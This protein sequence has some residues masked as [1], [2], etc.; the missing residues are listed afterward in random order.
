MIE[1]D[2]TQNNREFDFFEGAD[3]GAGEQ[4]MAIRPYEGAIEDPDVHNN[5]NH[6]AP[7]VE[8]ELEYVYGYRAEDIRMNC[9]YN[10]DK[11][12]FTSLLL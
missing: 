4:F 5:V 7:D 12:L 11:I 8:Y 2:A 6:D 1:I 10:A 9:F 3:A